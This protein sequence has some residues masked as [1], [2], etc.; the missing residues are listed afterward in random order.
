MLTA[1]TEKA[2]KLAKDKKHWKDSAAKLAERVTTLEQKREEMKKEIFDDIK[3][4]KP[5]ERERQLAI[6]LAELKQEKEIQRAEAKMAEEMLGYVGL[7]AG[8]EVLGFNEQ[9]KSGKRRADESILSACESL[10]QRRGPWNTEKESVVKLNSSRAERADSNLRR[11][12]TR[13]PK[14]PARVHSS[15]C[16]QKDAK[17]FQGHQFCRSGWKLDFKEG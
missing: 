7:S 10:E 15:S 9:G 5:S 17:K 16:V 3:R 12:W 1:E 6:E 11:G 4:S 13:R 8:L 14:N 2:E